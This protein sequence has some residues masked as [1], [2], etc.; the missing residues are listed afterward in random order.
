[1]K[2][3]VAYILYNERFNSGIIKNQVI[4]LLIE[5]N[6]SKKVE[7]SIIYFINPLIYFLNYKKVGALKLNLKKNLINLEL[8]PL[9]FFPNRI[10][11][12][13]KKLLKFLVFYLVAIFKIINLNRFKIVHCRSYLPS[14][15]AC[16]TNKNKNYNVIF[17]MRSLLPEE[18][19]II[20]NWKKD[21][22]IFNYWKEIEKFT[23]INS[24]FSVTVSENMKKYISHISPESKIINIEFIGS[25]NKFKYDSKI[26]YNIR[27]D[28]KIDEK[29]VCLY[30]GSLGE[31]NIH[32]NHQNYIDL[33]NSL[34][35]YK[36]L[37]TFIFVVPKI[38]KKIL[39]YF[40]NI[41]FSRKN[42]IFIEGLNKEIFMAADVGINILSKTDDSETRFGIKVAEYL[43]NGLPV[44][45]KNVGGAESIVK[46][47]NAGLIIDSKNKVEDI[48]HKL[49]NT[50][51]SHN[52]IGTKASKYFSLEIVSSKYL[53]LYLT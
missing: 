33:L 19:I 8:Y 18:N 16:L 1:M 42:I 3:K 47:L 34:T 45:L 15:I 40:D 43:S 7:I 13:K 6:K 4:K 11:F 49:I 35:A 20:G 38:E 32:N 46:S 21:S 37:I 26:R 48:F 25:I 12:L 44:I 41:S 14:Y 2:K 39:N 53:S 10:F 29:F 31:K 24:K 22:P 27:K 30:V 28:L 5:I 36:D 50:K 17:D 9:A 23:M 52:E 51:Y